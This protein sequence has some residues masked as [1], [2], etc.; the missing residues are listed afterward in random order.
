MN[1]DPP[2]PRHVHS[3]RTLL[4]AAAGTALGAVPAGKDAVGSRNASPLLQDLDS[5]I[6]AALAGYAIPG[7][8]VAVYHQGQ[9]YVRGYGVT[10][11][12][13]P[14]PVDA[15]TLF[16]IG[17][18]TKTFTAT[19]VMRLVEQGKMELD[20]PVR[21]YLPDLR[22]ADEAVA[23]RMTVRHLLDHS[24]GWLGEYYPDLGR[25][26]DA[27]ELY[28]AG[29]EQLPQLTPLGEVFAYNNASVVLAGRVLEVVANMPYE[30]V[31]Q[32]E[33]LGPLGLDHTFFYSDAIIGHNIAAPHHVVDGTP[34][35][36]PDWWR[37][38]RTLHPTGGLISSARDLMCYARFH[39]G[40][41]PD[42]DGQALLSEGAR[43]EMRMRSGPG[44]TLGYE[45]DGLGINWQLRSTSEGVPVVQWNGDWSGQSSALLFVPQRDFAFALL[46]NADSG[47]RLRSDLLDGDWVLARFAGLHIPPAIPLML[48]RAQ[49]APYEGTYVAREV[50]PPPGEA[51]ET[52]IELNALDGGLHARVSLD[53]VAVNEG[54]TAF[55]REDH[56]VTLDATGQATTNRSDFVRGP[57][58]R[59]TWL[60]LGGRLHR[61]MQ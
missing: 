14:Q 51:E 7:A 25:G 23:A 8:A 21:T 9:E 4:K 28:T 38:W 45:I 61:R 36:R 32:Q 31:V 29:L 53:G 17:S 56:V 48:S 57:D 55:Y 30:D 60:R 33:V 12:D 46:T 15:E 2:R 13:Y 5:E 19:T 27:L 26:A 1:G 40:V 3:R 34:T 6:E 16:R 49:L 42:P 24:S 39:L 10:N 44:G 50:A 54:N 18:V 35:V 58:G 47:A 22:L 43:R 59:I 37:L 20:A 41:L 52:M 11:A